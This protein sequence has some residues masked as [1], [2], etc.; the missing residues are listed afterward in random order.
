D[1]STISHFFE[2]HGSA[3]VMFNSSGRDQPFVIPQEI[4]NL[5][6]PGTSSTL[7]IFGAPPN[8]SLTGP[9]TGATPGPYVKV[10]VSGSILLKLNDTPLF[11]MTG[12]IGFTFGTTLVEINGGVSATIPYVGGVSGSIDF[13]FFSDYVVPASLPGAGTHLG[14]GLMGRATLAVTAGGAIPGV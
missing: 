2:F 7:T 9:A 13:A 4:L 8:D 6:P 14:P 3:K 11:T 5:M 1:F 10:K 12:T